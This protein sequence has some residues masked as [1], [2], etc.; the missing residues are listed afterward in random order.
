M[1]GF[2]FVLA[3]DKV[4]YRHPRTKG[5]MDVP[6]NRLGQ[7]KK[8]VYECTSIRSQDAREVSGYQTAYRDAP[9]HML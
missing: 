7:R 2:G 3:S 8:I 9:E 6:V 5:N 4:F 1:L